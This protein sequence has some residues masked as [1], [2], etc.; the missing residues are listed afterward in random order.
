MP[1]TTSVWPGQGRVQALREVTG[2]AIVCSDCQDLSYTVYECGHDPC[3]EGDPGCSSHGI[4]DPEPGDWATDCDGKRCFQ[5][6]CYYAE[7]TKSTGG[8]PVPCPTAYDSQATKRTRRIYTYESPISCGA[9]Q[10]ADPT[11]MPTINACVIGASGRATCQRSSC[12]SGDYEDL[13][14]YKG[15]DECT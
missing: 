8:C 2:G 12:P 7:C 1:T 5:Q 4:E 6:T 11:N 3:N 15:L 14:P 10:W 9:A 13:A